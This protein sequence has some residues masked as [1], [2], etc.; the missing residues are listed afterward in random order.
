M[1]EEHH[2]EFVWH[3]VV[4][5]HSLL[6]LREV[7]RE[8]RL[9]VGRARGKDNLVAVNGLSFNHQGNVAEFALVQDGQ[10]VAIVHLAR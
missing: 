5:G 3:V 4:R 6:P 9:E 10:E 7:V 2:E 1:L 8:G